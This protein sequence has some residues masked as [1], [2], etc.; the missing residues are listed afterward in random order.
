MTILSRLFE[1]YYISPSERDYK[2]K[3]HFCHVNPETVFT[4]NMLSLPQKT[5]FLS[6]KYAFLEKYFQLP[7][8]ERQP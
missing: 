5:Y 7:S 2:S 6:E 3:I 4:K 8:V 1:F